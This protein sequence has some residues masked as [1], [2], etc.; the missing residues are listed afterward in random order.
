MIFI[1]SER[2][3]TTLLI[4]S[5]IWPVFRWKCTFFLPPHPFNPEFENDALGLNGWNFACPSLTHKAN[6][7]GKKFFPMTSRLATVHPCQQFD[8]YSSTVGWKMTNKPQR[9]K[10]RQQSI[11]SSSAQHATR[12]KR[13]TWPDQKVSMVS[14]CLWTF[15]DWIGYWPSAQSISTYECR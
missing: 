6:Y 15:L 4:V 14:W 2:V 12:L 13:D 10:K 5:E 3:Y 11:W 1:S 8:R 9:P 7:S